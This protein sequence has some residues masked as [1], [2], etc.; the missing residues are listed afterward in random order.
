M[1]WYREDGSEFFLEV[2]N[3]SSWGNE[4]E[5]GNFQSDIKNNNPCIRVIQYLNELLSEFM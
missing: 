2:H 1:L 3:E 5:Q 4:L